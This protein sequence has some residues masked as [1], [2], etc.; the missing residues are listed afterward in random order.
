VN[1][2]RSRDIRSTTVL[3]AIV[4]AIAVLAAISVLTAIAILAVLTGSIG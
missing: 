2:H 3:A 1:G 4:A